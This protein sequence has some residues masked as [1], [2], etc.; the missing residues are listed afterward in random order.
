MYCS[1]R[2]NFEKE[3]DMVEEPLFQV[4]VRIEE[5]IDSKNRQTS[6]NKSCWNF[7]YAEEHWLYYNL[8][9]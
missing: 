9:F 6:N 8:L 3:K 2:V 1:N 5:V 4:S 7:D